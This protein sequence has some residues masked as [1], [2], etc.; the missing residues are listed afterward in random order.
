MRENAGVFVDAYWLVNSVRVYGE[1][2]GGG[3][4]RGVRREVG[5]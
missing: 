5:G 2:S 1:G 4:R 3:R